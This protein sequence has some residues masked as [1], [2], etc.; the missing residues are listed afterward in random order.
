MR[1]FSENIVKHHTKT[2]VIFDFRKILFEAVIEKGN[3]FLKLLFWVLVFVLFIQPERLFIAVLFRGSLFVGII[4]LIV[5][6]VKKQLLKE[7]EVAQNH[8]IFTYYF[9]IHN[10]RV[11]IPSR[12]IDIIVNSKRQKL[13]IELYNHKIEFLNSDDF[14]LFLDTFTRVGQLELDKSVQLRKGKDLLKYNILPIK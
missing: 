7:V 12:G 5:F 6:F 1:R 8:I 13:E 10:E 2:Q 9:K 3:N 14:M 4:L 11:K